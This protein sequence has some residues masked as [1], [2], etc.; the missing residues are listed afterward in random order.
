ML[1]LP[2]LYCLQA[3]HGQLVPE[4]LLVHLVPAVPHRG[5]AHAQDGVGVSLTSVPAPET[6]RQQFARHRADV[7]GEKGG[8]GGCTTG[9]G[10]TD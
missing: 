1:L 8:G 9:R 5:V 7:G 2:P 4:P 10:R 3:F 6:V